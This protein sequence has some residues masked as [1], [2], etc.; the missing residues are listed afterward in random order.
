MEPKIER[1]VET[2][3]ETVVSGFNGRQPVRILEQDGAMGHRL[4][5]PERPARPDDADYP[6]RSCER[7][8]VNS[9]YDQTFACGVAEEVTTRRGCFAGSVEGTKGER[10]NAAVWD[11]ETQEA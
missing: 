7:R 3:I 9:S 1:R 11:R 5:N 10:K 4:R 8:H 6:R 2:E